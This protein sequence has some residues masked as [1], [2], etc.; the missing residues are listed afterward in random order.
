MYQS[1]LGVAAPMSNLQ[2][3]NTVQRKVTPGNNTNTTNT[4]SMQCYSGSPEVNKGHAASNFGPHSADGAPLTTQLAAAQ[5]VAAATAAS[6][7]P[8]ALYLQDYYSS[9][10]QQLYAAAAAYMSY[11]EYYAAAANH[12]HSHHNNNNEPKFPYGNNAQPT[13]QFDAGVGGGSLG[14]ALAPLRPAAS[15]N[16]CSQPVGS[17]LQ[18]SVQTDARANLPYSPYAL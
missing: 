7:P 12:N 3:L 14:F 9:A 6:L 15:K 18:Q 4:N 5:M 13:P 8:T 1:Q 16:A 17:A 11:P 10:Q 2:L